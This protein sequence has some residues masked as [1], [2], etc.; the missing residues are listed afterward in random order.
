MVMKQVDVDVSPPA[1][2]LDPL[3]DIDLVGLGLDPVNFN[4]DPCDL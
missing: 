1:F 4:I 2:V 3:L